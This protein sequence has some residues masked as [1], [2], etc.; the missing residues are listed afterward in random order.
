MVLTLLVSCF[1]S[2]SLD[3]TAVFAKR[4]TEL[5]LGGLLNEFTEKG[6]DTMGSFAFSCSHSPG[7]DETGFILDVV[8]P[9]LGDAD[10]KLKPQLRRLFF[11]AYTLAALD[12]QRRA[13]P[14]DEPEKPKK[15][16]APER[17]SRLKVIK[18]RLKGLV[19]ADDLEPSIA[20]I[21]KFNS[22]KEEGHLRFLPWEELTRRD[23]EIKSVNKK[24]KTWQTD[25][26]NRLKFTEETKEDPAE[27]NT[28]LKLRAALQR[29]GVAMEM[30]Q[31]VTYE[32][33]EKY[34]AWLFKELT[35]KPPEFFHQVTVQ[36]L[37][38]VDMEVFTRL[39]EQTRE[40]LD[41][42]ADG[43]LVLDN[44]LLD[45]L[46]DQRI[47]MLIMPRQK[48]V[49]GHKN[50]NPKRSFTEMQR[51]YNQNQR[52][53]SKDNKGKGEGKNKTRLPNPAVPDALRKA[54]GDMETMHN[55]KRICFGYNLQG[56]SLPVDSGGSCTKGLHVCTRKGCGG[57]H[58]Q[59][60]SKCPM[61]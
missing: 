58:P 8:V 29:R 35:K 27:T 38:T 56:C 31:L 25:S 44:L 3:S 23:D 47:N 52:E 9:L 19:I 59:S 53:K 1:A 60:Y 13:A 41:M 12:V 33:H 21:D 34:V 39:A 36:Q 2:M 11:E 4:L 57:N 48:P 17:F 14:S 42:L 26:E 37:H 46:V 45:L 32:N 24:I 61:L 40:G 43:T 51:P 6:W 7:G 28:D 50:D 5:K 55:G 54:R 49:G 22:M 16:P 30:A 15:L 18:A 10:H 20:L